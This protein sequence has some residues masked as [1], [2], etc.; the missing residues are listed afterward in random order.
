MCLAQRELLTEE[1]C[2]FILK[3]LIMKFSWKHDC[4]GSRKKYLLEQKSPD[5]HTI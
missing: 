1:K 3:L 4:T 2:V 5:A